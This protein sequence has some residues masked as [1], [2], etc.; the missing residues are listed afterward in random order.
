LSEAVVATTNERATSAAVARIRHETLLAFVLEAFV[1][2]GVPPGDAEEAAEVLLLADVRGVESHGL[3]R[4]PYYANRIRKG[5]VAIDAPLA[6]VRETAATLAFDANN[7]LGLVQAP[8]A[9]ERC[10]AKAEVTGL[11]FATVRGSNHFGIAG[12]YALMAARRGLG[13]MAMTN[14]SPLVVP[15]FGARP[16]LGTN[17]IA[18][19]VPTGPRPDDPPLVLDMA[20]SAVAWGKIEVA[21]RKGEEIPLGWAVD[22]LGT[23]T[24]DPFAAR[25]LTPLGGER[26]TSGHKGY[27]LAT[28]VDVLCG[29]LAG[30]SWSANISG[31]RGPDV[32]AA[33]GH[34]FIAW[35]IDAFRDPEEFYRD[36]ASMLGELRSSPPA[37]GHEATGVIVPGD[38]ELAADAASRKFGVPVS[39]SVRR[40]LSRLAEE[41]GLERRLD[42]DGLL[43]PS[44]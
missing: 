32:P 29:P 27:G 40:D 9:M 10:I 43:R 36:L 38:P 6:V 11:C 7:G 5:L 42:E 19:A 30:A 33:I 3:A 39:T 26:A 25:W 21:R 1:A 31:S 12:A 15:T 34:A 14:A 41:L 22:E 16:L 28:M 24:T 13:G 44:M 18:V 2:L 17:P 20:T 37:V 4:L 23:P 8:R 35:R